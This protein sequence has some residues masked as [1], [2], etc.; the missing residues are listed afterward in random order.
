MQTLKSQRIC[1]KHVK[2]KHVK[3]HVKRHWC[4]C[5]YTSVCGSCECKHK[6]KSV[7]H[8]HCNGALVRVCPC[9]HVLMQKKFTMWKCNSGEMCK[10]KARMMQAKQ[11]KD[12]CV[13]ALLKNKRDGGKSERTMYIVYLCQRVRKHLV[14]ALFTARESHTARCVSHDCRARLFCGKS[15]H[16]ESTD[17]RPICP[18]HS[19]RSDSTHP[20]K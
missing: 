17:C 19:P 4:A 20:E 13:N 3:V 15:L 16:Q 8:K 5:R 14:V 6:C 9:K 7:K 18:P 11:C 12:N 1:G 10:L 2:F